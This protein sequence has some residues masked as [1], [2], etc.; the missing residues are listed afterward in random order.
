MSS[1]LRKIP[2]LKKAYH[3]ALFIR[4]M[5]VRALF[6]TYSWLFQTREYKLLRQLKT[7]VKEI[8]GAKRFNITN[9]TQ[10]YIG[11]NILGYP[12]LSFIKKD[13]I[14]IGWSTQVLT[15]NNKNL[16]FIQISTDV[17]KNIPLIF[18]TFK[19]EI[20]VD[21]GTASGGSA[22]FYYELL[23]KY[24][25][26]KILTI[27]ISAND[28]TKAKEF[29]DAYKTSEKISELYGKSSVDCVEEVQAFIASRTTGQKVL[30][31]FDNDH[32]YNHTYKELLTFAPLL[33]SGDIIL[34]Q[35]TWN[36]GLY[37]HETS[38]MLAVE[39]FLSEHNDFQLSTQVLSQFEMPCNFIYG[40]L[41]KK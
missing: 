38:P 39:R 8:H 41:Q 6:V 23:S 1:F 30:F 31:S 29:H 11:K 27:D 33:K 20:V 19:P 3:L 5:A 18:S 10:F 7:H 26:P 17:E 24:C 4:N 12:A 36:Q 34:M 40:V 15:R 21:F 9:K 2:G 32:T 22:V 28:V 14:D 16:P 25:Q 35:D 13:G 37:G